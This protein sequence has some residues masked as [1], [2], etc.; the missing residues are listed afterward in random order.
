MAPVPTPDGQQNRHRDHNVQTFVIRDGHG[1]DRL[2][3]FDPSRDVIAFDMAEING[4]PDVRDRICDV[5]DD[6]I[7]TFDN[8]DQLTIPGH[9]RSRIRARNFTYGVGPVC[10]HEGTP[11]R[12]ERGDIAIEYLRPDDIVWTKDHGWQA[13]RCVTFER[14][15]FQTRDDPAIP[16][17]IPA[18]AL[19]DG[20]PQQ[21]LI[22]SPQHRVLRIDPQSGKERLVPAVDLVGR[23]GIRHMRGRRK[24]HYLAIVMQRH[25]II[26]AAGCWV[27]SMLVTTGLLERQTAPARRLLARYTNMEPMHRVERVGARPRR[28]KAG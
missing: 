19:G 17:F 15:H 25:S 6:T 10:L 20:L 23:N 14:M 24:A 21:D 1:P 9:P 4:Y 16:I 3:D 13:I 2:R 27:E 18:G 12:T 11:I 22:T 7:I 26:Q 5:G 28:L 8:G